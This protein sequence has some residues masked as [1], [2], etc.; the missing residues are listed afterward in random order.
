MHR[1]YNNSNKRETMMM[2]ENDTKREEEE[3]E[4][5]IKKRNFCHSTRHTL[6]LTSEELATKNRKRRD[7]A[8]ARDK[9]G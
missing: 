9:K 2:E 6:N 5:K 8:A 1:G 7:R 3:E 4:G